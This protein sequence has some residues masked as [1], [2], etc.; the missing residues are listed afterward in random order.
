MKSQAE[1]IAV[2]RAQLADE[3]A[4]SNAYQSTLR[5]IVESKKTAAQMR[6]GPGP[7]FA[8][9]VRMASAVLK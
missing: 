6:V 8:G 3:R 1:E 5:N 2:L 9:A 4:R 7:A